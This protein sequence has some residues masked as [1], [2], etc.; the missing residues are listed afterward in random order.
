MFPSSEWTDVE[1]GGRDERDR[2]VR[3]VGRRQR[4]G[5]REG[6]GAERCAGRVGPGR[7]LRVELRELP[8]RSR[9]PAP[10]GRSAR[11]STTRPSTPRRSRSRSVRTAAGCRPSRAS[12]P[13]GRSPRW[14]SSSPSAATRASADF[15]SRSASRSTTTWVIGIAKRSRAPATTPVSSQFERPSGCVEMM[16]RPRRRCAGRPRSPGGAPSRRPRRARWMPPPRSCSTLA[17][18]TL[19]R[20]GARL[21]SSEA[22]WRSGRVQRRRDHEHL[23]GE[24][25]ARLRCSSGAVSPPTVSF[26]TTRIRRSSS[27]PAAW[28]SSGSAAWFA[29]E[30][31]PPEHDPGR[32]E[33]R[34]RSPATC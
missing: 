13:T 3:R 7:A 10:P 6:S 15:P 27:A 19:L 4:G 2:Y 20:R 16:T 32:D 17:S 12:S 18:D 8:T 1:R 11:T 26:A 31:E 23:L 14:R 21:S 9:P 34:P 29:A 24:P 28:S 22:Q 30:E 25:S 5:D 33:R